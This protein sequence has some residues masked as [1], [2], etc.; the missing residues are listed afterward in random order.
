MDG[1]GEST[2]AF[3]D[4]GSFFM[5]EIFGNGPLGLRVGLGF[6]MEVKVEGVLAVG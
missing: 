4:G 1:V 2:F 3:I 5:V 6:M